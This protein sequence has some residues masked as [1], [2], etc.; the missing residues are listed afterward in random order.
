[1]IRGALISLL[2]VIALSSSRVAAISCYNCVSTFNV[3][4]TES[5]VTSCGTAA[6][7][8]VVNNVDYC[9]TSYSTQTGG[10]FSG[11]QGGIITTITRSGYT[12]TQAT[13]CD[14]SGTCYCNTDK[15]NG[16]AVKAPTSLTCYQCNSVDYMDNGCGEVLTP[17]SKYVQTVQGCSACGKTVQLGYDY[18]RRY[19]RGCARSVNTADACTGADMYNRVCVCKTSMCNSARGL[20]LSAITFGVSAILATLK[21]SC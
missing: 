19:S 18:I 14:A 8:T 15:C 13:R 21:I 1:M 20:R 12:G 7:Q 2:V 3:T 5:S 17:S 6:D 11:T 9:T 16:D 4:N 10:P